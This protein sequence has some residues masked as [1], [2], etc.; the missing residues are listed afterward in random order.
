MP[1]VIPKALMVIASFVAFV[2]TVASVS[3]MMD[4]IEESI[5][6][7]HYDIE[8]YFEI[9]MIAAAIMAAIRI[10]LGFVPMMG[11]L[12]PALRQGLYGYVFVYVA[13]SVAKYLI[14]E[15]ILFVAQ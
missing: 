5:T 7:H 6:L 11:G 1:V 13:V 9:V 8:V 2:S 4:N 3:F 10:G 14:D 15:G 12:K